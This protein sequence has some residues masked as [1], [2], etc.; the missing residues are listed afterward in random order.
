MGLM[1]EVAQKEQYELAFHLLPALTEADLDE[2]KREIEE[3]ISKN[4]G[5]VSR[6]GEIKKTRLA[7]PIKSERFSNFGYIE[8]FAPK[9]TVEE[10][11]KNLKLNENVLRHLILKKEEEMAARPLKSF[12]PKAKA[13]KAVKE[14]GEEKELDKKI[15]EILEKL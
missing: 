6:L 3:F 8:F 11:N 4:G 9:T 15:E 7:Y 12:K 5:L 13:P 1:E 10:I 2:K 14:P